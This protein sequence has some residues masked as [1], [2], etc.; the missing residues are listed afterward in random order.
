[1]EFKNYTEGIG[2]H[3][4]RQ[5]SDYL[6]KDVYGQF[7]IIFARKD[8][9]KSGRRKQADYLRNRSKKLILVID[10]ERLLDM[11]NLKARGGSPEN[12]LANLKFS[13][14]TSV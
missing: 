1:M 11:I 3:G 6:E 12:V 7:G 5:I 10:D 2:N 9:D 14:E 8:L 13:I 4:F